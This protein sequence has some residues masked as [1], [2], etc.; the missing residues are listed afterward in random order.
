MKKIVIS[1]FLILCC[2]AVFSQ[3]IIGDWLANIEVNGQ[4]I[5]IVFHFNKDTQGK[6]NGTWDSPKQKAF[7]LPFSDI[8]IKGDSVVLLIKMISGFYKGKMIVNDSIVGIWHQGAGET[9]LNFSRSFESTIDSTNKLLPGEKELAVTSSGTK[10]YGTLLS[11]NN[12]Q[13]LVIIIAGS[14]PTDREGNNPIGVEANS[15]K[16][17]AQSLDSQNIASFRYDKRGVAKSLPADFVESKLL[18]DD[19]IKDAE[20]IF[21]YL[22]DTLGYKNIYFIGHSEG[23]LI[24]IVAAEKKVVKGFISLAGSGRPINEVIEEQ[25][26]SQ[27]PDSLQRKVNFILTELKKGN[28]VS[29]IPQSL[30]SL[31][32][33]SIQPYFISWLKYSPTKEINKLNC[34]VLV[35]QG[36]CD[37]QI[38][39]KDAQ[40]LHNANKKSTLDIISLMTH[41]LKNADEN[42]KDENN[43]TYTDGSLPLNTILV[44]D[45]VTFIKKN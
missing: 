39:L 3:K 25:V 4:Q 36:T 33:K 38:Q 18:F 27:L 15:Y 32:R 12:H 43:K 21:N 2:S 20:T 40:N 26:K 10:I 42:C 6:V 7:G 16:M 9:A 37:K 30:T 35:L 31:F 34:P 1:S 23:S 19:Y 45:I 14:G 28:Q 44:K 22:F 17:I 11:K 5:P 41:T 29:D 24:G 13:K 8:A